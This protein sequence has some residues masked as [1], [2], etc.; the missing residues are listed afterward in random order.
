MPVGSHIGF[1]QSGTSV[2]NYHLL[3][4][5][6]DQLGIIMPRS[7]QV[8]QAIASRKDMYDGS[9]KDVDAGKD[10]SGCIVSSLTGTLRK[11]VE[12]HLANPANQGVIQ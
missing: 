2:A 5:I 11:M 8:D 9:V 12:A 3:T 1:A 7:Y 10:G 4:Q 6:V